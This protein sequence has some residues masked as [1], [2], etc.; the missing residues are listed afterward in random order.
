MRITIGAGLLLCGLLAGLQAATA[1][2]ADVTD[3]LYGGVSGFYELSDGGRNS[4]NGYGGQLFGGKYLSEHPGYAIEFGAQSLMRKRSDG[5]NDYQYA[6]LGNLRKEFGLY[7][8]EG[9]WLPKFR[10]YVIGGVAI[11]EEDVR[12]DQRLNPGVDFGG[13]V[14]IPLGYYGASLRAEATG[15]AQYNMNET[16]GLDQSFYLDGHLSLGLQIAFGDP[17]GLLEDHAAPAQECELAVVDPISGRKDCSVDSDH[18][19]VPDTRDQ[20]PDT[21]AGSTV[22]DKGCVVEGGAAPAA[23]AAPAEPAAAMPEAAPAAEAPAA[24][25]PAP[26]LA[27]PAPAAAP[28]AVLGPAPPV[29]GGCAGAAEGVAVD[30]N[31]CAVTQTFVLQ[32]IHFDT[33][34]ALLTPLARTLL[35]GI[36]QTLLAQTDIRVE[37]GGHTDTQGPREYNEIL[38]KLRAVTVMRYLADKGVAEDRMTVKGYGLSQ[39][40]A[41]NTTERG[42]AQ[43]RR[44]EFRIML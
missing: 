44:V 24:E 35:D 34:S 27:E 9:K 20:C 42:R 25:A 22:D 6:L 3:G 36:A 43:N 30:A 29:A 16:K 38:S 1:S 4:Q 19:G 12:G 32:P 26:A 40:V 37:I 39:P 41:P 5:D 7:G 21:P 13:G 28:D 10:P 2:A 14:L 11:I 8:W 15:L 17:T 31:G 33:E 23:E 18:D